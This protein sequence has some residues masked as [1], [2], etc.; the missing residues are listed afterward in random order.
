MT[1]LNFKVECNQS[2]WFETI[3]AFNCE[4]AAKAYAQAC[5]ETNPQFQYRVKIL[6]RHGRRFRG[7]ICPAREVAPSAHTCPA[8]SSH[9]TEAGEPE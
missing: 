9:R 7:G 8:D 6:S 5:A 4:P 3:A 2:H 1:R